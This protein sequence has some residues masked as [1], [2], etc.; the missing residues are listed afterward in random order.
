M[1]FHFQCYFLERVLFLLKGQMQELSLSDQIHHK[2]KFIES[3]IP[4]STL[5]I[6]V[7]HSIGCH[8]IL[9]MLKSL[10]EKRVLKCFFLFPTI[11]WM[12]SSPQGKIV[13]PLLRYLR[14]ILPVFTYP[15][16]YLIPDSVKRY[17]IDYLYAPVPECIADGVLRLASPTA[18]RNCASL[19]N[20]EMHVVHEA[21]YDTLSSHIDKIHFY[22]G[23]KD[24]WCP[25]EYCHRMKDRFPDAEIDLCKNRIAHAFVLNSS[26]EVAAMLWNWIETKCEYF[27]FKSN[28][29]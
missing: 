19:A 11:E 20:N 8:M 21:D 23:A 15:I 1:T 13:T 5:L 27:R 6:L 12:S 16:Y 2:L 18:L 14:W 24:H 29:T 7:G 4:T 9:Q 28:G 22:Y 17:L 25:V 3:N 26:A 10:D